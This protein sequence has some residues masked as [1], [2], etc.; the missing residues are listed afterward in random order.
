MKCL[1]LV[2]LAS[3]CAG[4]IQVQPPPII[5]QPRGTHVLDQRD[6]CN[7]SWL[8]KAIDYNTACGPVYRR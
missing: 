3:A 2:V 4:A 7:L 1:L 6:R 5:G 8:E